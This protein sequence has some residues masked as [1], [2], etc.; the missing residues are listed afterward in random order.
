MF[1]QCSESRWW[2]GSGGWRYDRLR[3]VAEWSLWDG[4]P[5]VY[6]A[7]VALLAGRGLRRWF[8]PVPRLAGASFFAVLL[9]LLGPELLGGRTLLPIDN[10]RGSVPF[11]ERVATE[12]HGNA[13]H[14]DLLLLIAPLAKEVREDI[15]EGRWPLWNDR[16]GIGMPLLADPQ[17]Q[18]FQPLVLLSYPFGDLDRAA[19][20]A[21]FRILVALVFTF[22]FLKRRECSD[23]PALAGAF[24]FGLGGFLLLWLGWPLANTAALF[25]L[26]LYSQDRALRR[27]A[28]RDEILFVG[29]LATFLLAGH[30]ETIALGLLAGFAFGVGGLPVSGQGRRK[31][32]RRWI[33]MTTLATALTA[34]LWLPTAAYLPETHR[35]AV[36]SGS[37]VISGNHGRL[38]EAPSPVGASRPSPERESLARSWVPLVAP[39][40]FGNSRY[41]HYWGR[42]NSNED[43]SGFSGTAA[44]LLAGL[45][46]FGPRRR[47]LAGERVALG[48]VAAVLILLALPDGWHSGL[49]EVPL[50]GGLLAHGGR[51]SLLYLGFCLAFLA[52]AELQR[53]RRLAPSRWRVAALAMALGGLLAWAYLSFPH[54]ENPDLLAVLRIGWLH[55]QLRFLLAGALLLFLLPRR[56]AT[57]YAVA[58]LLAT[59]LCLAHGS[60]YPPMPRLAAWP[61]PPPLED[62]ISLARPGDR[63][64]GLGDTLPPNL[65]S[66]YGLTDLRIYNPMAPASYGRL[67]APAL[68]NPGADLP[69]VRDMSA[70]LWAMLDAEWALTPPGTVLSPPFAF[71]SEH[72]SGALYRRTDALPRFFLGRG[73][74]AQAE[75]GRGVARWKITGWPQGNVRPLKASLA[76]QGPAVGGSLNLDQEGPLF[77]SIFQHGPRNP[78]LR[79]GGWRVLLDG[80]LA[81]TLP[82]H[83]PLLAVWLP[84]RTRRLDFVYRPPGFLLGCWLAALGAAVAGV[85]WTFPSRPRAR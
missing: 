82:G 23:G 47:R 27:G 33:L 80:G 12:P 81:E 39:N 1:V 7:L 22:L 26:L 54:P 38:E 35:H 24:A 78:L 69:R 49:R 85:R 56:R 41:A 71:V 46:L 25:P 9:I 61:T 50:L 57:A 68:E 77:A 72:S 44:L 43:A 62:L 40:A 53:A 58:F 67:L 20:T 65:A 36:I 66:L 63:V 21:A 45:A 84:G 18:P 70:P 3:K 17:A 73:E 75:R 74:G 48:V 59:E 32:F 13:L 6:V 83:E 19:V 79:T 42:Q 31:A 14:G 10:L 52:A 29:S 8:D 15:L 16:A 28:R 34:P 11:A 55:W 30:P 4:L 60:A 37:H 2:G 5:G 76:F 51:R 64:L